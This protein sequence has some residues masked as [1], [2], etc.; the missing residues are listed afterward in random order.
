M[1]YNFSVGPGRIYRYLNQNNQIN[2]CVGEKAAIRIQV[3]SSIMSHHGIHISHEGGRGAWHAPTRDD[4]WRWGPA[5]H[6]YE[7]HH[8]HHYKTRGVASAM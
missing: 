5:I 7:P 1:G 4:C 3:L 2:V 8:R 6:V